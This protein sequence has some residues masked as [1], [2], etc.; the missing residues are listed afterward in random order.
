MGNIR[1][2]AFVLHVAITRTKACRSHLPLHFVTASSD[3]SPQ[4]SHEIQSARVARVCGEDM[5]SSGAEIRTGCLYL[6]NSRSTDRCLPIRFRSIN[7][8]PYYPSWGFTGLNIAASSRNFCRWPIMSLTPVSKAAA[9]TATERMQIRVSP[10]VR[11]HP[12][13]PLSLNLLSQAVDVTYLREDRFS[14][15]FQSIIIRHSGVFLLRFSS[16]VLDTNIPHRSMLFHFA[17][18]C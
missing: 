16:N 10:S 12:I 3:S 1:L 15:Y 4:Y 8:G 9:S 11:K 17:F 6:L 5:Y 2:C 18:A 7:I 14:L 13:L